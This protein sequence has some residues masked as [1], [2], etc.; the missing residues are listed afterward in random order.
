METNSFAQTYP[1]FGGKIITAKKP[2][3]ETARKVHNGMIDKYPDLIVQCKD[4]GDVVMAVNYA[5]KHKLLLAVKGGGH[6]GAGLGMC[7]GGMVIDMSLMRNVTV[8]PEKN[9]VLVEGGCTL[10]DLDTATHAFGLAVPSGINSTTGIGGLTLGGGLGHLTRRCG[11]TIDNLLEANMVLA[12]GR[13]VKAS[14]TENEDLFWAVRGGGGNFGVVVSFLFRT[15]PISTVY[16]GPMFWNMSEAK[17]LMLWYQTFIKQAPDEISGFFAFHQIP[18]D[19]NMFP[20]EFHLETMCGIVWCHSG[21]PEKAEAFF[22]EFRQNKKPAI[23]LVGPLPV[24]AIQTLFDGLFLPGY[25]WYWKGDFV[26]TLTEEVIDIHIKHA[27]RIPNFFSGMHLYPING[28]ASRVGKD[29]TAW[30]YR[31]ATWAMVI[32]GV[33]PDANNKDRIINFSRDYWTELHPYNEG[34]SYVNFM[35]E[36]GEDRIKSTYGKNYHRLVDIKGK[37]DPDN[38]FRVNQNIKPQAKMTF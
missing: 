28:A 37:Y 21:D 13:L 4:A 3:Y 24:P 35:M 8:H 27:W 38:L 36:E 25:Q 20:V 14:A 32:A 33:D 1:R 17:E 31:D 7:D 34:G 12:D 6:N 18:P 22:Q 11:L 30:N 16:G 23:D 19:P 10:G 9:T 5:R 26:K 15:H 2:E 29:E